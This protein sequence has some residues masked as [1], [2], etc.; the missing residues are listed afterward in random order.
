MNVVP[1]MVACVLAGVLVTSLLA[2]ARQS[3]PV[4]TVNDGVYTQEQAERGRSHYEANCQTCHGTNLSG[5]SAQALAG[6]NFLR[7]WVGLRLDDVFDRVRAM[8]PG[9]ASSLGDETYLELLTYM[10]EWNGV[11]PGTEPLR[12]EMLDGVL[13]EGE[14]GPQPAADFSLVQVVGCLTRG[15]ANSWVVT[16]ASDPV[17]TRQP[18]SSADAARTVAEGIAAWRGYLRAFVCLSEP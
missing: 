8:P 12:L 14:D 6:E 11:Q 4:R 7:F 18:E 17:R 15:P 9:A 13:I 10:L 16:R 1:R 3:D 2:H 5:A